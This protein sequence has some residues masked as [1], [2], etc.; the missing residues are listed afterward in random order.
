M[1]QLNTRTALEKSIDL[2]LLA[3]LKADLLNFKKRKEEKLNKK[4]QLKA[5]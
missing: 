3:M 2:E 5:A 4:E 1:E